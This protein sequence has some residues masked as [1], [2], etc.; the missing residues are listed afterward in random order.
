VKASIDK[1]I[2]L[3]AGAGRRIAGASADVPKPLLPLDESGLTF[4][5]WHL[6]CLAAH[7]ASEIFLVGNSVTFGTRIAAMERVP[8]TWILN[9]A[10]AGA[11]GSGH[12]AHLA[13]TSEHRILDGVSRVVLM[14]ADVVYDPAL[15]GELAS[16]TVTASKTLVCA[17]YRETAEEVMVFGDESGAP[18]VH[19]KG[20]LGTPLVRNLKCLGEA[21][22]LLLLEPAEH[23]LWLAASEWCMRFST[24]KTRSEHEDV[25]QRIMLASALR[26]VSFDDD[27]RFMECDTPDEYGVVRKEM[28]PRWRARL[29]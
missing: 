26:A 28:V 24:A 25:T 6:R 29:P 18:R 17:K 7:G 4:L 9:D 8:A 1:A 13:F 10:A 14:D 21:T 16:A 2:I 19:G 3:A 23:E 12:S 22:G 27:Q 11:T 20:L 5:D 15:V